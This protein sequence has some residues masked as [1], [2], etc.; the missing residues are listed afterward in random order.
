MRVEASIKWLME[1]YSHI[2]FNL[3][4]TTDQKAGFLAA[5]CHPHRCFLMTLSLEDRI[6]HI[7]QALEATES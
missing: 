6:A 5:V 7:Q 2:W 3:R 4:L 1:N